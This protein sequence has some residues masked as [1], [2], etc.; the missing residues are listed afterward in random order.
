MDCIFSDVCASIHTPCAGKF[1]LDPT[2]T[3]GTD[4]CFL[5]LSDESYIFSPLCYGHVQKCGTCRVIA[6][7]RLR[8]EIDATNEDKKNLVYF[9][10]SLLLLLLLYFFYFLTLGLL[11]GTLEER[12]EESER[13]T[14]SSRTAAI[15]TPVIQEENSRKKNFVCKHLWTQP[16]A[17]HNGGKTKK[18]KKKRNH[19]HLHTFAC[20]RGLPI[21]NSDRLHL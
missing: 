14:D 19:T 10:D 20:K 13:E 15:H 17:L 5:P 18:K 12:V 7:Q 9:P 8:I 21:E 1:K 2:R 16:G 11:L 4:I 6:P 3:F